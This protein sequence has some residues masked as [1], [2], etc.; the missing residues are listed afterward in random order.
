MELLAST[1]KNILN[2]EVLA[3]AARGIYF[4]V[5]KHGDNGV[6]LLTQERKHLEITKKLYGSVIAP[7]L[8]PTQL[9]KMS[10]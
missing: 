8:I 4:S 2:V 3:G 5:G 6:Y 7:R 1:N 9:V 10:D